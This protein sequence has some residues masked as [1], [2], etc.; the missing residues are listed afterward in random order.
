[1]TTRKQR[2]SRQR[3]IQRPAPEIARAAEAL[4]LRKD[5]VTLLQYVLENK[6]VGT[7][8]TGNM[9]LKAVREVTARFVNPPVLDQQT[10][11]HVYRLR[12]EMDVWPLFFL[13]LL[14]VSGGLLVTE[15]GRKWRVTTSGMKFLRVD[16]FIQVLF[17]LT[18]WWY[19]VNWL[20]AY[21]FEGMGDELPRGFKKATM[22]RLLSSPVG[23]RIR[24]ESFADGLI[25]ETGLKWGVEVEHSQDILRSGIERM[26][27]DILEDFGVVKGEY[28]E[29]SIGPITIPTTVAFVV[30]PLGKALLRELAAMTD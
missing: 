21:P 9:P 5:M 11:D 30:T 6:V 8:S 25:K 7:R 16:A 28:E 3:S 19:G 29:E 10:G 17:L 22:R 24:F 27:V 4:P 1:M 14:A 12:S 18:A 13:H 23:K 15:P 20:V 26:V 2:H